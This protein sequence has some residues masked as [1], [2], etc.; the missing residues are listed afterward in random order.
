VE[1]ARKYEMCDLGEACWFLAMEI[2]HDWVAQT[3]SIDQCQYIRKILRCFGL[4]KVQPVSTPMATN[5]KLPKMESL[6][7][8]QHVYQSMLGSLM[9]TV[10]GTQPDIMFT[11]HYLSQHSI[12]LGEK[13]FN[14]MK[15]IYHYLNGTSDL[16]LLFYR[17]QFN[18]N[19]V[20]FSDLD[21]ASD[22]NTQRLVSGYTFLFCG[23][24]ITWSVKKQ[25]TIALSST[26]VEYM[27]MTHSGFWKRSHFLKPF[28]QQLGNSH[29]TSNFLI[30]QQSICDHSCG[31][32]HFPH[33]FQTHRGSS[34]LDA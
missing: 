27:A 25:P 33:P 16:G 23:A 12:A 6:T 29:S 30:S 20:G 32:S 28:I 31:K 26:E 15:C 22:P 24:I 8:D 17:N 19:P 9:Y 21:W 5:L 11:I 4:D 14:V 13:H 7:I 34:P 2:T 3:I 1:L 18:H 10:I